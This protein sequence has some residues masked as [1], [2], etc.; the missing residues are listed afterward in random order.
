MLS[1]LA[2]GRLITT[3]VQSN[4]APRN[5]TNLRPEEAHMSGVSIK[6]RIKRLTASQPLLEQMMFSFYRAK[7]LKSGLAE[8]ERRAGL[9]IYDVEALSKEMP[10][11]PLE[12]VI[13]NN[14]YGYANYLKQYA[15][16]ERDLKA[17]MEHGLFLGKIVH[18]DQFAW[19][20]PRIITMSQGRVDILKEKIPQKEAIAVGP[21]I[22]YAPPLYSDEEMAQMKKE[23]GKTL[24]VYPFHSMKNVKVGF[25]EGEFVKEIKRVA[26]D[27][28][29]VLVSL[30]FS[31]ALDPERCAPYEAEGF[32]LVTA[33]H[34]FDQ[35]FVARQRAHIE[36]SDFTM[37]NGMGTQTG[38]C[39]Y[40][41]KPHYIYRQDIEQ[42]PINSSESARFYN[43]SGG[44]ERELVAFQRDY[45]SRLFGE[46]RS[47]ISQE[48]LEATSKFWG[49]DQ[50][51]TKEELLASFG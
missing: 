12:R 48:Q 45:F 33:G 4:T 26:K 42:K 1:E 31:D 11:V 25:N 35:H 7:N 17:Y 20:F 21:Y 41:N 43:S 51:K 28:D 49:F 5:I 29:N 24:L 2:H 19:H 16:I 38:F 39:V 37:S 6:D 50:V 44:D 3:K 40:L 46:F 23:L 27:F 10:Y 36:L 32:K 13:D 8:L 15:G 22:H 18:L 47:D 14:I 30:Y 9:S 34:R